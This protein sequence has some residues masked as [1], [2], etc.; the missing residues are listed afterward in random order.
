MKSL[1]PVLIT[2]SITLTLKG[3]FSSGTFNT[4]AA[5]SISQN[6]V[7]PALTAQSD[8]IKVAVEFPKTFELQLVKTAVISLEKNVDFG[9]PYVLS[10]Y[11]I[12]AVN[13]ISRE[14]LTT[15]LPPSKIQSFTSGTPIAKGLSWQEL[16]TAIAPKYLLPNHVPGYSFSAEKLPSNTVITYQT[17]DGSYYI[18]GVKQISWGKTRAI[19]LSVYHAS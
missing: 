2:I 17:A 12:G 6:N 14:G 16:N 15:A 10:D 9:N 5:E 4:D 19:E 3:Y 8:T 11:P 18:L 7:S 1:I 13:W